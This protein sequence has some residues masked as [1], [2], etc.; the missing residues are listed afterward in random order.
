MKNLAQKLPRLNRRDIVLAC[1][2]AWKFSI[3]W[4]FLH[5]N[6]HVGYG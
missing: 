3:W 4:T 5:S 1:H 2:T 6:L